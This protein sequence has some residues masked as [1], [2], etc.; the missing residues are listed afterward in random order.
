M[1]D[2]L[3]GFMVLAAFPVL[4]RMVTRDEWLRRCQLT[5]DEG[6][7]VSDTGVS[8]RGLLAAP[9]GVWLSGGS[10]L[11]GA[12][13]QSAAGGPPLLAITLPDWGVPPGPPVPIPWDKWEGRHGEVLDTDVST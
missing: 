2:V 9:V 4:L 6:G 1:T 13:D 10:L 5:A 7:P 3:F 8:S 11:P 12:P